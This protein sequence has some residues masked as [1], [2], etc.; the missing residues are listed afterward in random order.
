MGVS[1]K[2]FTSLAIGFVILILTLFTGTLASAQSTTDGSIAGTVT[3]PSGAMVVGADVTVTNNGTGLE[4]KT[5]TDEIGYFRVSKLQPATYTVKIE[6]KGF[7]PYTAQ[8]VV[9]QVGTVTE[10]TPRLS[11]ASAGATVVVNAEL[12]TVNTTSAEIAPV[13]DQAQISNLPINGGRWSSFSL[14]T[15]GAV[16][17]SSGFGLLSFRGMS[18][19]LNNNTV[20]GADNNQGF[21]SEERGRTRI[22]YSSAKAAVQEFQVNTSNYSAE[23]GRSAGAVVNTVTKSGSNEF[24]GEGYFY[25]RDNSWGAINPFTTLTTQTSPGV[26]TTS[27]Y[28]PTDVRKMYGFGVGGR[29]VRDKL[30]FYFAF[31]R[32]YRNFPGTAKAS[33]PSVFFAQPSASTISTLAGRLGVTTTEAQTLY[34]NG[35]ND[36]LG[37]LGPVPRNGQATIFFP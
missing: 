36:L 6:A 31:D 24:H 10:M 17:D 32:Y 27:P 37:E 29:I 35:L 2:A 7:A 25:D 11:V 18:T 9:V 26:Y 19:L 16:S 14:L 1:R 28:A 33:N 13:V 23:Y 21:F 8:N 15:P 34:N 22:G 20:D 3:D 30:F 12:P 5:T 4:S